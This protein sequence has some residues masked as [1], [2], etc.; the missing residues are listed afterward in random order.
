M[1]TATKGTVLNGAY[2]SSAH[3]WDLHALS[4]SNDTRP[5]LTALQTQNH[6]TTRC[7]KRIEWNL[8]FRFVYATHGLCVLCVISATKVREYVLSKSARFSDD[9]PDWTNLFPSSY[10]VLCQHISFYKRL[11]PFLGQLRE[12]IQGIK[13]GTGSLEELLTTALSELCKVKPE[14]LHAVRYT[15]APSY[16]GKSH[17]SKV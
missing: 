5:S 6:H 11:S 10:V 15:T 7:C 9:T 13:A 12:F 8:L 4:E 3:H 2:I 1:I 16:R 17:V 14:G